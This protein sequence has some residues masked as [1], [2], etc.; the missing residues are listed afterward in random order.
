MMTTTSRIAPPTAV[1]TAMAIARSR[2][3]NPAEVTPPV[4]GVVGV[5]AREKYVNFDALDKI[6]WF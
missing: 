3:L 1:G 6:T 4:V 5:S 2:S